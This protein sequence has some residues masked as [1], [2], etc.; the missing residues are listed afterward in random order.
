MVKI[1]PIDFFDGVYYDKYARSTK[2]LTINLVPDKKVYGEFLVN[3][4]G[5][6]YRNWDV[7]KSKLGA[8]I[9]NGIKFLGFKQGDTVLY[10]GA[11]TGTTV[12]STTASCTSTVSC[13]SSSTLGLRFSV[14]F[15]SI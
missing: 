4:A 6:Q 1:L 15:S 9:A 8:G 2:I 10:L 12:S 13:C 7:Y 3:D 5:T 11:S 14:L